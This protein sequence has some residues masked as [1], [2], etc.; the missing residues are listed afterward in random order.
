MKRIFLL[1]CFVVTSAFCFSQDSLY[2]EG[3]YIQ[4]YLKSE[5]LF[6]LKNEILRKDGKSYQ[7]MIDYKTQSYFCTLKIDSTKVLM[8]GNDIESIICSN[9]NYRNV[10]IY[11]FPPFSKIADNFFID[12]EIIR[13]VDFPK[14]CPYYFSEKDTLHVFRIYRI[15]GHSLRVNITNDYL[16]TKNHFNLEIDWRIASSD[17]NRNI[18][19]FYAYLF[20]KCDIID[21]CSVPNGF[22]HWVPNINIQNPAQRSVSCSLH[23]HAVRGIKKKLL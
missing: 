10:E 1:F 14:D 6:K 9:Q 15:Q 22:I 13:N 23:N 18:P 7:T 12:K 4:R 21:C 5:I 2:V 20:Y 19:A 16:D 8:D 17:I 3:F 11:K